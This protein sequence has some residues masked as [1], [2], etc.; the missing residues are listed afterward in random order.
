[1]LRGIAM[2]GDPEAA[3]HLTETVWQDEENPDPNR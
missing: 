2:D 1:M 3:Q